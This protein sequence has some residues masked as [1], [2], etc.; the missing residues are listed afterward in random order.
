[1]L[2]ICPRWYTFPPPHWPTISL[3][4]TPPCCPAGTYISSGVHLTLP[5]LVLHS[6]ASYWWAWPTLHEMWHNHQ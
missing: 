4:L 2:V 3:P 5:F 1:M 6:L